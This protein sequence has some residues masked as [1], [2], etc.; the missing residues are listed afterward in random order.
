LH[1][2]ARYRRIVVWNTLVTVAVV[3]VMIFG[4][5]QTR[6][7]AKDNCMATNENKAALLAVLTEGI[8]VRAQ[9]GDPDV[10]AYAR[11]YR[12]LENLYL[13]PRQC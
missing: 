11:A 8:R 5:Y 7:I 3:A 1:E 2:H 10:A 9:V 4:Y 12:E 6:Q 13:E